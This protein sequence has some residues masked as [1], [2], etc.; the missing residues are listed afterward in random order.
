MLPLLPLLLLN[1]AADLAAACTNIRQLARLSPASKQRLVPEMVM[2]AQQQQQQHPQHVPSLA[3]AM[4]CARQL[5]AQQLADAHANAKLQEH[6]ALVLRHVLQ[7]PLAA[8]QPDLVA[9]LAGPVDG[10][11]LQ[12]I[13]ARNSRSPVSVEVCCSILP[14]ACSI[15]DESRPIGWDPSSGMVYHTFNIKHIKED[16]YAMTSHLP[17]EGQDVQVG[18]FADEFKR[19]SSLHHLCKQQCP[20]TALSGFVALL[21]A[22][23]FCSVCLTTDSCMSCL[24]LGL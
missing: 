11:R 21:E 16:E 1:A 24:V 8:G 18:A 2:L 12:F 4:L 20:R 22:S 6:A 10:L 14:P 19:L 17:G 13:L 7:L 15:A 9:A 3:S 23:G 5:R